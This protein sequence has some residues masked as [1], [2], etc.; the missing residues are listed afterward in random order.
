MDENLFFENNTKLKGIQIIPPDKENH[1]LNTEKEKIL[2]SST[3]NIYSDK[4]FTDETILNQIIEMNLNNFF[5]DNHQEKGFDKI[6]LN[7]FSRKSEK[8]ID[9][10]SELLNKNKGEV[11]IELCGLYENGEKTGIPEVLLRDYIEELRNTANYLEAR[12][13]ILKIYSARNGFISEIFIRKNSE[14]IYMDDEYEINIGIYG[15]E[16]SGKSTLLSVMIYGFLD[17][18]NGSARKKIL[19][20][21]SE[22]A[23]GKTISVS[24]QIIGFDSNNKEITFGNLLNFNNNNKGKNS[25]FKEKEKNEQNKNYNL[26]Q[27]VMKNSGKIFNFYDLGGSEKAQKNSVRIFYYNI[28]LSNH[29]YIIIIFNL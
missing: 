18:G 24:Y 20:S 5:I 28:I 29:Y 12:M 15:E 21:N 3:L 7:S 2:S 17:N 8:Q 25:N 26:W 16:G 1:K 13:K 4:F 22:I 6:I 27:E 11:F 19:S 23:S 14:K 10:L 9:Q